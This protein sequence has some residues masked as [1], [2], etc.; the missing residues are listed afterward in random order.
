[1]QTF[2]FND[3]NLDLVIQT[4]NRDTN[5][6]TQRMHFPYWRIARVQQRITQSQENAISTITLSL[7]KNEVQQ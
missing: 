6:I 1:V 5:A 2:R 4:Q 7:V 3:G